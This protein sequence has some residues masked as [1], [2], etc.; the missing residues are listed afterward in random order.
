MSFSGMSTVLNKLPA[1]AKQ[2]RL[3]YSATQWDNAGMHNVTVWAILLVQSAFAALPP[4]PVCCLVGGDE[5]CS[6]KAACCEV[7]READ[8][9]P[10]PSPCSCNAER[11]PVAIRGDRSDAPKSESLAW[12]APRL[13]TCDTNREERAGTASVRSDD[14]PDIPV[15]ILFCKWIE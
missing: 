3:T 10:E 12:L 14:L 1:R 6:R 11:L 13:T 8:G 9:Q 2:S 4:I 7:C 15:R 5:N